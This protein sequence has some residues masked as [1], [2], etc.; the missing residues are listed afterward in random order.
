MRATRLAVLLVA[1]ALA[2]L[3][4]P[5]GGY[6]YSCIGKSSPPWLAG[7]WLRLPSQEGA[8]RAL[9]RLGFAWSES[10]PP[11]GAPPAVVIGCS[12]IS[13][14]PET[15]DLG[16]GISTRLGCPRIMKSFSLSGGPDLRPPIRRA[17][18]GQPNGAVELVR[19]IASASNLDSACDVVSQHPN[20]WMSDRRSLRF[21]RTFIVEGRRVRDADLEYGGTVRVIETGPGDPLSAG[22]DGWLGFTVRVRDIETTAQVLEDRGVCFSRVDAEDGH[23][24]R[25][26]PEDGGGVMVEFIGER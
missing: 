5:A 2:G 9:G 20:S 12:T 23:M 1:L 25:V 24:L 11:E 10:Q 14:L 4:R 15:V 6:I 19:V 13:W 17:E 22:T 3:A 16:I 18:S 21:G 26:A 8:D 7:W